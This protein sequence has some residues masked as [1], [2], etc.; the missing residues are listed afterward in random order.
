M[1]TDVFRT[2][3]PLCQKNIWN[4]YFRQVKPQEIDVALSDKEGEFLLQEAL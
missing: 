3:T 4:F 1:L 2:K